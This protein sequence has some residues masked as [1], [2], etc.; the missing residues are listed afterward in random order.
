M[1]CFY[2]AKMIR[3]TEKIRGKGTTLEMMKAWIKSQE[4]LGFRL[5][6]K[7]EELF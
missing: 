7:I 6:G 2:Q 1:I 4:K 3:G 5:I